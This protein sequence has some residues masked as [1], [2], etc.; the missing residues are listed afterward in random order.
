L[1]VISTESCKGSLV[2]F[3]NFNAATEESF[4]CCPMLFMTRHTNCTHILPFFR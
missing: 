1:L 3:H 4:T 2:P